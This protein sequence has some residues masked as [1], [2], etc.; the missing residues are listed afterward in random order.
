MV[1]RWLPAPVPK[2]SVMHVAMSRI[3]RWDWLTIELTVSEFDEDTRS[4][5]SGRIG[6]R[7]VGP[8]PWSILDQCARPL[9][10]QTQAG[11]PVFGPHS[12]SG[13]IEAPLAHAKTVGRDSNL[14][15]SREPAKLGL[16]DAVAVLGAHELGLNESNLGSFPH[17][18]VP[19]SS[20][21][22]PIELSDLDEGALDIGIV[23]LLGLLSTEA[24][25][26]PLSEKPW[27]HSCA[28]VGADP[29]G[30]PAS[31]FREALNCQLTKD[32]RSLEVD[33]R[34]VPES[35]SDER[36]VGLG[37]SSLNLCNG[38]LL[39]LPLQFKGSRWNEC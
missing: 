37:E 38:E 2:C 10:D 29:S 20:E 24:A 35:I 11:L 36:V 18:N 31:L 12:T 21:P 25:R 23:D 5:S 13:R 9:R 14:D 4:I 17:H 15:G 3:L 1:R 28:S 7:C 39:P 30:V 32:R 6:R 27:R 22:V 34:L 8:I 19:A 26:H 16:S 33:H